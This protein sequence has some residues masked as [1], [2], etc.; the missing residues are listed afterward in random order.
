MMAP[1]LSTNASESY[2]VV[3][4]LEA[5]MLGCWNGG[6]G[7]CGWK[8]MQWDGAAGVLLGCLTAWRSR[9]RPAGLNIV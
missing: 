3:G 7:L 8:R 4:K 1:A 5:A 9:I 6:E 2:C